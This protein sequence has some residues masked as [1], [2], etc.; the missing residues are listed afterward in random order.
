MVEST[1]TI[2][3][4]SRDMVSGLIV[5][6]TAA[7]TIVFKPTALGARPAFFKATSDVPGQTQLS[8]TLRGFARRSGGGGF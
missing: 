8:V 2:P 5:P 4:G 1:L 6:G 7:A 3:P